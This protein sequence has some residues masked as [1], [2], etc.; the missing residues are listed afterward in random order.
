M[1][2][3]SGCR[4]GRSRL[5]RL[6]VCLLAALLGVGILPSVLQV[7]KAD[8]AST[9]ASPAVNPQM[10]AKSATSPSPQAN[11]TSSGSGTLSTSGTLGTTALSP[12][13]A[14]EFPSPSWMQVDSLSNP[15]GGAYP[16][17]AYDPTD[18]I[19][20]MFGG[21]DGTNFQTL[22]WTFSSTGMWRRAIITAPS[23]RWKACMAYDT[24]TSSFVMFGGY[25]GTNSLSDTWTYASGAW[26]QQS[27]TTVPEAREGCMMAYDAA[28]SQVVMFGGYDSGTGHYLGDTWTWNGTTWTQVTGTGP[29]ARMDGGMAYDTPR[30][31]VV[32]F[33]GYNGSYLGDTWTFNGTWTQKAPAHS[34]AA[35][36]GMGMAYDSTL[37]E[38]IITGGLEST[39]DASDIWMYDGTGV[40]WQV[41]YGEVELAAR[42]GLG[43]APAPTGT[44]QLVAFGG[45]SGATT[46]NDTH[47]YTWQFFGQLP[48]YPMQTTRLDDRMNLEVNNSTGNA[49]IHATDLKINEVGPALS[50]DRWYNNPSA[51]GNSTGVGWAFNIGDDVTYQALP[52]GSAVLTNLNGN[53]F[54]FFSTAGGGHFTS[55]PGLD[56]DLSVSGSQAT[57]TYHSSQAKLVL[58]TT[59][60]DLLNEADRNGNT[61]TYTYNASNEATTISDAEGRAV[62]ISYN[63]AKQ[64]TQIKDSTGRLVKY[65]YGGSCAP[66]ASY[67]TSFTDAN[68]QVTSYCYDSYGQVYEILD[69]R[70]LQTYLHYDTD[71]RV[72]SIEYVTVYY[73]VSGNTYTYSYSGNTS[74]ETKE[75]NPLSAV[76][77]YFRD[78]QGHVTQAKDADNHLRTTTYTSNSDPQTLKDGLSQITTLNWDNNTNVLDSI[79]EPASSGTSS[80]AKW[81]ASYNT[82][83]SVTGYKYLPSNSVA[84]PNGASDPQTSCQA[85]TYDTAG[86]LTDTWAAQGG[87]TCTTGTG[88]DFHNNLQGD[89]GVASC[90]SDGLT[91]TYKGILCSTTYVNQATTVSSPAKIS[92]SYTLNSSPKT[93]ASMTVTQPGGVCT[94]PRSLCQ[95]VTFDS[96]SRVKSVQDS[97]A[98]NGSTGTLTT[99][100]YDNLDRI[101]KIYYTAP[102]APP[103]SACNTTANLTYTYDN[104][105]NVTQRV[106]ST[107]TTTFGYDNQNQPITKNTG[108][109]V[110]SVTVNV[111][112]GIDTTFQGSVCLGYDTA[113]RV[114]SYTDSLGIT[115]YAYDGANLL[116]SLVEPGGTSG[117]T[118]GTT[119][120]LCTAFRNDSDGRRTET[121]YPG[122]ATLTV[123]YDNAGHETSVVGSAQA[124]G[125][126]LT[127]FTY[128][129]QEL[130]SGACP[131]STGNNTD[132]SNVQQT[133][134]NDVNNVQTT[135]YLYDNSGRLCWA[136]PNWPSLTPSCGSPPAS[137]N[138]YVYDQAGNRTQST[139]G[140]VITNYRYN[141]ANQLCWSGTATGSSCSTV[142][143][144]DTNYQPFDGDGQL[145]HAVI[146]SPA[147]TSTWAYNS[148]NQTTDI[149]TP[150]GSTTNMTYADVG[151]AE[152]TSF[153]VGSTTTNLLT[154]PLGIDRITTGGAAAYVVRDPHGNLIGYVDSSGNHWYYLL[155]GHG[156][157]AGVINNSGSTLQARYGY[158]EYGRT[159]LSIGSSPQP[160]GYVGG[161]NDPTGLMKFGD[162]YYDPSLG[163]WT[164]PDPMGGMVNASSTVGGYLYAGDDPTSD[165]DPSGL[166]VLG[167][168]GSNCDTGSELGGAGAILGVLGV[169][170]APFSGGLS[171]GLTAAAVGTSTAGATMDYGPAGGAIAGIM[172]LV[173]GG[174]GA[175]LS[176]G[177]AAGLSA[178]FGV[179]SS[180][181]GSLVFP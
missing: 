170:A 126:P 106:D 109:N 28:T 57:L 90:T 47:V 129:Y 20:M 175:A 100:C 55:P 143:T 17:Y 157:V 1:R 7:A 135:N 107:G 156:S 79:L 166:C 68:N 146:P 148:A 42:D 95:T 137:S 5:G 66:S 83:T 82:S 81:T 158:D 116:T 160:F 174:A 2:V 61:T 38:V 155:D 51:Y 31:D 6:G 117:C 93:L 139:I 119:Q 111:P 3:D 177:G 52:D 22:T 40:D 173:G 53:T 131:A 99:Y 65:G 14:T 74:R 132:T 145:V 10:S 56:A 76:T 181:T 64:I 67:L 85:Y 18:N 77:Q 169:V 78:L 162:R 87:Q 101:T 179:A 168:F 124:G 69:P 8:T 110:C 141:A 88:N 171:L 149:T 29:G 45:E 63:G 128:C 23:G 89:G 164:Q 134:E 96:L 103:P 21:G 39:G 127:S 46:Y 62:T 11:T 144:G 70:G 50:I 140:G 71:N 36:R 24:A 133:I 113:S 163:R 84:P 43:L 118:I 30:S 60:G 165:E 41:D 27:P 9:D 136:S 16:A 121:Q 32:L 80:G 73:S 92:Y 59:N 25:D 178:G 54:S 48:Y 44:G 72:T 108:T 35:R 123:A 86:N 150:S 142:P 102:S 172:G 154:G 33:A 153:T 125:T 151:Q 152:R 122:G 159:T 97:T 120:P 112:G 176:A 12:S 49:A 13:G 75:T 114:T 94:T 58:S 91:T 26:T 180:L 167:F 4:T 147:F 34:P 161:Y 37:H 130:V 104:D 105:G 138:S 15:G 98:L 19:T 115:T